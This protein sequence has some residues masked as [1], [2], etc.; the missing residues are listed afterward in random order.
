[1][2]LCVVAYVDDNPQFVALRYILPVSNEPMLLFD[3]TG[4]VQRIEPPASI[5]FGMH[6]YDVVLVLDTR[7]NILG[8]SIA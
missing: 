6:A 5:K 2:Q 3:G 8:F 1:V 4:T 7:T